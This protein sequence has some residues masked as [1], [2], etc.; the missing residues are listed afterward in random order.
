M[1]EPAHDADAPS[2]I[3]PLVEALKGVAI[4]M[5]VGIHVRRGWFGW[6][7]VHVFIVL[8]GFTLAMSAM[9]APMRWRAWFWRRAVRI[10]PSFWITAMLGAAGALLLAPESLVT[11]SG[12]TETAASLLLR[13]LTLTRNFDFG[14]MFGPLNASLWYVPLLVGLYLC[15]PPIMSALRRMTSVGAMTGLM[16]SIVAVEVIAR[17]VA[18]QWLDGIPVGAGQGFMRGLGQ[19]DQPLDHL[20]TGVRFQLWAPFG[21]FPTRVAEFALGMVAGVLWWR[22]PQRCA[23]VVADARTLVIGA[24]VWLAACALSYQRAGWVVADLLIAF[25]L[26]LLLAGLLTRCQSHLPRAARGLEWLGG[27]SY[28][29]FLLHVLVGSITAVLAVRWHISTL[30]PFLALLIAAAA[31]LVC[32]CR[33]LR[34]VDVRVQRILP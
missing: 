5:I 12:H 28:Q 13:D 19:V 20:P 33:L 23:R 10:L 15:F 6:Q 31:V 27:W 22:A 21:F 32:S 1:A 34:A 25:G 14:L 24:G 3:R 30:A 11:G 7:G 2:G 4:V 26:P 8:S 9:K 17:A 18:I 16:L 29:V